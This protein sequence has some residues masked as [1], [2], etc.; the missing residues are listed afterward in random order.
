MYHDNVAK[1]K[2]IQ[3]VVELDCC[4]FLSKNVMEDII[5]YISTSA[6]FSSESGN[7]GKKQRSAYV[8]K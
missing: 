4:Q 5:T 6:T 8:K 7:S 1:L 3:F 2:G